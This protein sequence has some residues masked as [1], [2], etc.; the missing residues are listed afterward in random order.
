M[1]MLNRNKLT[2]AVG[3]AVGATAGV[4]STAQAG[5]LFFPQ[6]V[7]GSTVTTIFSIIN[8]QGNKPGKAGEDQL[9]YKYYYKDPSMLKTPLTGDPESD[10]DATNA[11]HCAEVDA[12][13]P[14]SKWDI[15]T[16]D[17]GGDLPDSVNG[18]MFNDPSNNNNWSG[19]NYALAGSIPKP[20]RG[21]LYVAHAA[22]MSVPDDVEGLYGEAM[23]FEFGSGAAWG[24][25]GFYQA[26]NDCDYANAASNSPSHVAIYPLEGSA[27]TTKFMVTPLWDV[28]SSPGTPR[29]T[30]CPLDG[31]W[32][33]AYVELESAPEYGENV[34]MFDRDENPISGAHPKE[35][36]CVGAI[37]AE[38]LVGLGARGYLPDGGW[39]GVMNYT[40]YSI[41]GVPQSPIEPSAV[42][43]KLEYGDVS[44][45]DPGKSGIFN[46]AFYLMPYLPWGLP[47]IDLNGGDD[48]G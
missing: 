23:I 43:Y 3:I 30:V 42:V 12:L 8:T 19:Y 17:I 47:V 34:L 46:N 26:D 44:S 31:N 38:Y 27:F 20:Q 22:T 45:I 9:H 24:Y 37:T 16:I 18:V 5:Q 1:N 11:L 15:Q 13:L 41:G 35:V 32:N 48:A 40:P 33:T 4:L 7:V 28:M 10:E 14:T 6:A 29:S 25:Q 39:T 36:A 21:Y 2:V